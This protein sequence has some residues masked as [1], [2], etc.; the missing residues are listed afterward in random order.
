MI[1]SRMLIF[2]DMNFMTR[3]ENYINRKF[4]IFTGLAD[5]N[6]AHLQLKKSFCFSI[7]LYS[8]KYL[9]AQFST[10]KPSHAI[11]RISHQNV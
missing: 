6:Y 5:R 10:I 8:N 2:I 1:V 3:E 9:T 11:S 7:N 4:H